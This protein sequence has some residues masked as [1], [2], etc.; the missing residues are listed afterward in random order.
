MRVSHRDSG[1]LPVILSSFVYP[2]LGQIVQR[3]YWAG[4][5]YLV[6]CTACLIGFIVCGVRVIIFGYEWIL[7]QAERPLPEAPVLALVLWLMA[8][9]TLQVLNVVDVVR[10]RRK[11]PSSPAPTPPAPPRQG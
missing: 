5:F 2:G 6:G 8:A 11:P 10:G 4:A 1:G 3:R 7:G 9:A